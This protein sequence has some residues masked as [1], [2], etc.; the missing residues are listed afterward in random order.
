MTAISDTGGCQGCGGAAVPAPGTQQSNCGCG[1]P[2]GA[3]WDA[4]ADTIVRTCAR[5]REGDVV[6]LGGGLHALCLLEAL[7]LAVRRAGGFP[8][9]NLTSQRL[10]TRMAAETPLEYLARPPAHRLRWLQDVD[11]VIATDSL[12]D[13]AALPA[14]SE[15]RRQA[16]AA[17]W[18]PLDAVMA[19]GRVR[20][21]YVPFP[22]AAP[23]DPDPRRVLQDALEAD[24]GAMAEAGRRLAERLQGA[25]TLHI[26]GPGGAD[27]RLVWEEPAFVVED[28]VLDEEA[29]AAGRTFAELP[30]GALIAVPAEAQVEGRWQ[31]PVA[32]WLGYRV[33]DAFV[34]FADGRVAAS[35]ATGEGAVPVPFAA[36]GRRP[37]VAV[38]R[39]VFG[40]NP[41][42]TEL[43]GHGV[44]DVRLAG[45]VTIVL[46][47]GRAGGDGDGP[48]WQFPL[49]LPGATVRADGELVMDGGRPVPAGG[50]GAAPIPGTAAAPDR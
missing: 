12:A 2:E 21:L 14:L 42:V 44:L 9:L 47:E 20:S 30:G 10:L 3:R 46:E 15:E 36:A 25:R 5:V 31:A 41:R 17:G 7:A 49:T 37:R 18:A 16:L 4:A 33:E 48:G 43:T 19:E 38:S 24:P 27:L 6:L 39:V 35:G 34:T 50:E 11:V 26:T 45:A 23:G 29:I 13:P 32:Y 28:G 22:A 8:E 1:G 40:L